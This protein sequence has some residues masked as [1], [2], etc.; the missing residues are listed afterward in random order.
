MPT[1]TYTPLANITLGSQ[2]ASVTFSSIPATYRDLVLIISAKYAGSA[3]GNGPAIRIN[4]ITTSD[5]S[6]VR[7]DNAV[8][9]AATTN[10][11]PVIGESNT[12][13]ALSK[14][15]FLDASATDK[16]KSLLIRTSADGTRVSMVAGR[17]ATTSAIT[18]IA[19]FGPDNF[20][21]GSTPDNWDVGSSFALYGIVA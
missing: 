20:V 7:T 11:M 15:D 5:Y 17:V 21:G 9:G 18:S 1:P 16:H 4:G 3:T 13:F 2:A 10:F 14:V 19:I 8:S 12:N 6:N